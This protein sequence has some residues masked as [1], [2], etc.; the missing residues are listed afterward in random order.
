MESYLKHSPGTAHE[1]VLLMKGFPHEDVGQRYLAA[2]ADSPHRMLF[3][4]DVGLDIGAY[5]AA[6]AACTHDF[7]CFVNSFSAAL[8]P[9]WLDHLH[10]HAS[11]PG[12]GVAAATGSFASCYSFALYDAEQPS[13]YSQV[14]PRPRRGLIR[15]VTF[16]T[17]TRLH[18]RRLAPRFGEFPSVHVRTNAFVVRR[19]RFLALADRRFRTK[20]DT[21]A[22][23]SGR[24]SLTAQLLEQGLEPVVVGRDGHAYSPSDWPDSNTFWQE[25]QQNLLVADNQTQD[26]DLAAP[27]RKHSLSTFAWADRARPGRRRGPE[28]VS[29]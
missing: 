18:A 5:H 14:F 27:P 12:V 13:A 4:P 6:A 19:D 7:L 2:A 29:E 16:G 21:M 23:E 10:R 25:E 3:V 9:G 22:F 8:I 24:E 1:L 28:S 20:L 26:Y 15:T 17:F 11:A